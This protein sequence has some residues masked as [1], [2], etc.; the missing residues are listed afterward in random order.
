MAKDRKE[1]WRAYHAANKEK[2]NAQSRKWHE[3]N[4]EHHN[5]HIRSKRKENR[6]RVYACNAQYR[7]KRKGDIDPELL[8]LVFADCPKGMQVDHIVSISKGGKNEIGNLQYL[9]PKENYSKFNKDP[10][11][12]PVYRMVDGMGRR[13]YLG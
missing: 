12:T 2:R 5:A 10:V 6:D 11:F 13:C 4:K 7:A 3:D 9:T 1:R 8:A